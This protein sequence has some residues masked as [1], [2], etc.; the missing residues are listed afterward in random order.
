MNL[1]IFFILFVL[2]LLVGCAEK[3]A[4]E[5]PKSQEGLEET[6]EESDSGIEDIFGEGEEI[7]PPALP[8]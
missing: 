1:K 5:E 6:E 4:I 2:F 3:K 7:E 8:S